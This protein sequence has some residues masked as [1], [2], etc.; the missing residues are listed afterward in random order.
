[1][2]IAGTAELVADPEEALARSL[3]QKYLGADAPAD[4]DTVR[5]LIVPGDAA[6]DHRLLGVTMRWAT[7]L[8]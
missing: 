1:M 5:R 6:H 2:D 4:L 3:S 8:A 7:S